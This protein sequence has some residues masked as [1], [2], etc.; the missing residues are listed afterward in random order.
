MMEGYHQ[1]LELICNFW[2]GLHRAL[3]MVT[4]RSTA[5]A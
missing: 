2:R 5:V 3:N 1:H 4:E